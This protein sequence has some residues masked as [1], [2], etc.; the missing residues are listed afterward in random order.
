[1]KKYRILSMVLAL[2][3]LMSV[4][5]V[6]CVGAKST[7][8]TY[9][10][11]SDVFVS[12][13]SVFYIKENLLAVEED[14]WQSNEYY[15]LYQKDGSRKE[16]IIGYTGYGAGFRTT[17]FS[18]GK[19]VYYTNDTN[20]A[21][22]TLNVYD[23]KKQKSKPLVKKMRY[24]IGGYG[25]NAIIQDSKWNVYSVA[26]NGKKT[27]LISDPKKT[28]YIF[29]GKLFYGNKKYD[30]SNGKVTAS[31]KKINAYSTKNYLYYLNSKGNL[32]SLDKSGKKQNVDTKVD[33]IIG[34]NNGKTVLYTKGKKIFR[35]SA[36]GKKVQ[37]ADVDKLRSFTKVNE[38]NYKNSKTEV[39]CGSIQGKN[40]VLLLNTNN[41]NC[42]SIIS[43]DKNGKNKKIIWSY[44]GWD[45]DQQVSVVSVK[46]YNNT[47]FTIAR[48]FDGYDSYGQMS[49]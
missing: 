33:K 24:I 13:K 18:N 39:V 22:S 14:D 46:I 28:V 40:I 23:L 15:A 45:V 9:I 3:T 42:Q 44:D 31:A 35:R 38:E 29:N 1:M 5:A 37:L 34:A 20:N 43:M 11:V 4:T 17:F 6:A 30:L 48:D 19:Y 21:D 25:E 32:T 27:K 12:G 36:E 7:P 49:L 10:A 41:S 47:V 2:V 16:K 8:K 26:P